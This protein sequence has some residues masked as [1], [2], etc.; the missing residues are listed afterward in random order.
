M[1][2]E[3]IVKFSEELED[4]RKGAKELREEIKS[5]S[6]GQNM[7][8]VSCFIGFIHQRSIMNRYI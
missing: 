4:K 8:R 2:K 6:G 7:P 1:V 5:R 3:A